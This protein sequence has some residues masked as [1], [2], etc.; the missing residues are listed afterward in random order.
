MHDPEALLEDAENCA[1]QALLALEKQTYNHV[2]H[3]LKVVKKHLA[4][5]NDDIQEGRLELSMTGTSTLKSDQY[6]TDGNMQSAK[7]PNLDDY[8]NHDNPAENFRDHSNIILAG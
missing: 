2:F 3:F 7:K 8:D 1:S 6:L 5:I 4:A